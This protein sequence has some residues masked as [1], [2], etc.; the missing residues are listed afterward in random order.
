MKFRVKYYYLATG[1]EGI[2]EE[3][4]FG[5][6]R[7]ENAEQA[8]SIVADREYPTDV[9]YGPQDSW[10]QKDF[11]KGCLSARPVKSLIERIME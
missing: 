9:M 4:D 6:V 7:A 8:C 5:V 2:P 10:S 1:M 11:F 3:K